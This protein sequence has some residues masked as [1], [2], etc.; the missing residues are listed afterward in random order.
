MKSSNGNIFRV[1]DILCGEFTGHRWIPLKKASDAELWC[2]FDL[3]LNKRLSK[4]SQG[5]WFETPSCPLWRHCNEYGRYCMYSRLFTCLMVMDQ[6]RVYRILLRILIISHQ[7]ATHLCNKQ[8]IIFYIT[9][10]CWGRDIFTAISQTTFSKWAF[11]LRFHWN[12]F[13]RFELTIFQHWLR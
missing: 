10:T 6:I 5:W 13:L 1:T 8:N 12:L 9:W 11:Q 4:Q 2:F 3:R 7:H